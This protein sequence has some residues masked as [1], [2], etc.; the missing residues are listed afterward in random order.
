[1][2]RRELRAKAANMAVLHNV[3]RTAGAAG[4]FSGRIL[5]TL[6]LFGIELEKVGDDFGFVR[7]GRKTAVG[8]GA[9]Q[10]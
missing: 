9:R 8:V 6:H 7:V 2:A 3:R 1:M 10:R 5:Q 4:A